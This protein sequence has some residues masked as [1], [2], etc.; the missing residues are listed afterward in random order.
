MLSEDNEAALKMG[1]TPNP[2]L[3]GLHERHLTME[4]YAHA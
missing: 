2:P 1:G 4:D 3:K